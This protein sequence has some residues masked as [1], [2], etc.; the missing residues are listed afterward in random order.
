MLNRRFWV[1]LA[2]M[3]A[4]SLVAQGADKPDFSG[5][6][7]LNTSKSDLGQMPVP[8]KYEM[9]I[10]HKD[11]DMKTVTVSV[12]QMG[13]RTTEATY[14]TDGTETTNRMGPNESK[15]VAK[16]EGN[17]LGIVTKA[18]FQGNDF[19]INSKWSLSADGKTLTQDQTMKGSQG[20]FTFKRVLDKQ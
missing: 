7:K 19:E 16:W 11:P 13:E 9:K 5:N 4:M 10:D 14:K 1:P 8:D 3:A 2:L 12:G 18:S 17:I 15:S 6:W 20:E